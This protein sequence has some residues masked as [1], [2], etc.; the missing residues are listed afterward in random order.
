[1]FI[2][3][4][5]GCLLIIDNHCTNLKFLEDLEL[6]S[7]CQYHQFFPYDK[8]DFAN[9]QMKDFQYFEEVGLF[10]NVSQLTAY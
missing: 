2:D 4:L 5:V 3:L 6:Y 7:K 10:S 8:Y 9:I 1:M